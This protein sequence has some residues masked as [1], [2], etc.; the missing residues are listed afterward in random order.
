MFPSDKPI[1]LLSALSVAADDRSA[2]AQDEQAIRVVAKAYQAALAKGD[3]AAL[4]TF[5]TKD[6]DFVDDQGNAHPASELAAEATHDVGD[7][8]SPEV[9]G[10]ASKIRFLTDDVA[11]ED[12]VSEIVS[13][14]SKGA[15]S[16]R[17]HYHATWVKQEG[18][19]RLANL[20]EAPIPQAADPQLADLGWMA[21]T[22]IGE[23]NDATLKLVVRWNATGTFLLRDTETVR[24][25]N[26][27]YRGSQRIGWDPMTRN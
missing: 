13:S 27:V 9:I 20:C 19:W 18:H 6:G 17:G 3:S 8:P 12:G 15:P 7:G 16:V 21:G 1:G 11:I 24:D 10:P 2:R 23:S 26:I 25:G 5:W 14:Q 22:W 4:A